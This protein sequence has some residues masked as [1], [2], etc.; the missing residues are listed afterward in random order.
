[1]RKLKKYYELVIFTIL[2]QMIVDQIWAMI[3]ELKELISHTLTMSDLLSD[4]QQ[5][6]TYKDLSLLSLNRIKK[7]KEGDQENHQNE[8]KIFVIDV[9]E[10]EK[11]LDSSCQVFFFQ[12]DK[13]EGTI[14]YQNLF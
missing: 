5:K 6:E 10:Y 2:P 8:P 13:Y 11:V 1:M 7:A 3:P 4:D 9:E 12:S 14:Q